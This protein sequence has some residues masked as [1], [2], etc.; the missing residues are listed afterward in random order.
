MKMTPHVIAYYLLNGRKD[1]TLCVAFW[2]MAWN[3][4]DLE[5]SALLNFE[6]N[7]DSGLSIYDFLLL[8]NCAPL[9]TF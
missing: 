7:S 2:D 3:M 5:L 4:S 8:L 6:S 9:L 1:R